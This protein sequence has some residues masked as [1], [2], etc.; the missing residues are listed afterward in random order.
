MLSCDVRD[1]ITMVENMD[2]KKP[3]YGPTFFGSDT[4]PNSS[5]MRSEPSEAQIQS[6]LLLYSRQRG[7]ALMNGKTIS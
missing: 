3:E 2:I 6:T 5:I 7:N 4:V 1:I